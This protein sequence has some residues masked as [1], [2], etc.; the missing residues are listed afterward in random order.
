[1]LTADIVMR[2]GD[3]LPVIQRTFELDGTPVN[4]TGYSVTFKAQPAAGGA[5]S[6]NTSATIVSAVAG[7]VSY[8]F[9]SGD[10]SLTA[11][12]YLCRF[13]GTSGSGTISAPN[14]GWLTMLVVGDSAEEIVEW[15]YSG[16]PSARP[17]DT[18][19]FLIGDTDSTDKQL[20]DAE[21]A[22]YLVQ[23]DGN[24]YQAGARAC[25]Q[26]AAKFSRLAGISRSVGDLSI[27]RSGNEQAK[28]YAELAKSIL[29]QGQQ[30]APPSPIVNPNNL[31]STSERVKG[32]KTDF[33]I[34]GMDYESL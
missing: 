18:V 6:I 31:L 32:T 28:A 20:S 9:S 21:L 8:T 22:W 19:R 3:R 10:A 7:T 27:S 14:D 24:V 1:M 30:A 15:S 25:E 13:V 4:L 16:D 12:Y 23:T 5:L 33:V 11:G 26:V 34:G 29:R 17:V 2:Q